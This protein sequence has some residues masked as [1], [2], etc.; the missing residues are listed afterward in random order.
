MAQRTYPRFAAPSNVAYY[1]LCTGTDHVLA[2]PFFDLVFALAHELQQP[3]PRTILSLR[4]HRRV[5][6][7]HAIM[8]ATVATKYGWVQFYN[9]DHQKNHQKNSNLTNPPP[10]SFA[11]APPPP[12]C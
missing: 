1:R 4:L 11:R 3:A 2:C 12:L 10:L 5:L 7:S 8:N 9:T 6:A